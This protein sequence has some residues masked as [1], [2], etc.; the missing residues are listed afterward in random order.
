MKKS[1]HPNTTSGEVHLSKQIK[2]EEPT[3][4]S[5]VEL[6]SEISVNDDFREKTDGSIEG[7]SATIR[8]SPNATV[9]SKTGL[10]SVLVPRNM[11]SQ[12]THDPFG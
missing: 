1:D 11:G 7:R 4:E 3:T 2:I 9:D 6:A 10:K 8:T 12:R 5:P